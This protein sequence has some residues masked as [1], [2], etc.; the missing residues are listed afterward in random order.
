MVD[1][2]KDYFPLERDFALLTGL[3]IEDMFTEA[4]LLF[5]YLL[6]I[7]VPDST[8]IPDYMSR[9]FGM[10]SAVRANLESA[11]FGVLLQVIT[12]PFFGFYFASLVAPNV[13]G[14]ASIGVIYDM[15]VKSVLAKMQIDR[16]KLLNVIIDTVLEFI[17][18]SYAGVTNT[19]Q[20]G[21]NLNQV[22]FNDFFS[23]ILPKLLNVDRSNRAVGDAR[24]DS[25]R[26][27]L[28]K[29][30]VDEQKEVSALLRNFKRE[31]WALI[32]L[33]RAILKSR[34][35]L[36]PI[37]KSGDLSQLP[38]LT[39]GLRKF[40]PRAEVVAPPVTD[41]PVRSSRISKKKESKPDLPTSRPPAVRALSKAR[42]KVPGLDQPAPVRPA[43]QVPLSD[44]AIQDVGVIA[45][46]AGQQVANVV[47][48]VVANVAEQVVSEPQPARSTQVTAPV[49]IRADPIFTPRPINQPVEQA[50][51]SLRSRSRSVTANVLRQQRGQS[52]R[53]S[54][55]L[56]DRNQ[57]AVQMVVEEV[58]EPNADVRPGRPE[59]VPAV[60]PAVAPGVT[61]VIEQARPYRPRDGEQPRVPLVHRDP[62]FN[63]RGNVYNHNQRMEMEG[64]ANNNPDDMDLLEYVNFE[65]NR[66][67]ALVDASLK[68]LRPY[69]FYKSGYEETVAAL[70]ALATYIRGRVDARGPPE[71]I[72]ENDFK[73]C[74]ATEFIAWA[75]TC[76]R[77]WTLTPVSEAARINW[78]NVEEVYRTLVAPPSENLSRHIKNTQVQSVFSD[79]LRSFAR[80]IPPDTELP[81]AKRLVTNLVDSIASDP[82]YL[83]Y[84]R[85]KSVQVI[86][87]EFALVA[88]HMQ[89]D[90]LETAYKAISST[91]DFTNEPKVIEMKQQLNELYSAKKR[92]AAGKT[93][94]DSRIVVGT[95]TPLVDGIVP[96]RGD[97]PIKMLQIAEFNI[98]SLHSLFVTFPQFNVSKRTPNSTPGILF[99][100][101]FLGPGNP[102]EAFP[103]NLY[104]ISKINESLGVAL[105]PKAYIYWVNQMARAFYNTTIP[106]DRLR[107]TGTI[108]FAKPIVGVIPK[109]QV[110][111][112]GYEKDTIIDI[113][114]YMFKD[115]NFS[116]EYKFLR[117]E[118]PGSKFIHLL[119]MISKQN[120][121]IEK[122]RQ[123]VAKR[124]KYS[125]TNQ[126]N[127]MLNAVYGRFGG[128]S[129]TGARNQYTK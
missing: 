47:E 70:A 60:V 89:Q 31:L 34:F 109:L 26:R 35:L 45:R 90:Q 18:I 13:Q 91:L 14:L 108:D 55:N 23:Q 74:T 30:D 86:S 113:R 17:P 112:K 33:E 80:H 21:G 4:G 25:W 127:K 42:S 73:K 62:L 72:S 98:T 114:Q 110:F 94:D 96:H 44:L 120:Y 99:R 83:A 65:S 11:T 95:N 15:Q 10:G 27:Y 92:L 78:A 116:S 56:Y 121:K 3:Q 39:K 51:E 40:L 93:F 88:A 129:N 125:F 53:Q 49:S 87:G 82:R 12:M 71:V 20:L 28:W 85:N 52:I 43:T 126:N 102:P 29:F 2:I 24:V 37:A 7:R 84:L 79:Y 1:V 6:D 36:L 122:Y 124:Q 123:K 9:I 77:V 68:M 76:R 46:A 106:A 16:D 119:D 101:L 48:Q 100:L 115:T 104:F 63:I 22:S 107:G 117:G 103:Q 75:D 5:S 64:P 8:F 61:P 50:S 81:E 41:A 59:V 38:K 19:F 67:F 66:F 128:G 58:P 111:V 118:S 97:P 54:R 32:S 57:L 69:P 105:R